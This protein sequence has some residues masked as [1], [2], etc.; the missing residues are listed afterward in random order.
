MAGKSE[1]P[2]LGRTEF[3]LWGGTAVVAVSA[4]AGL[5]VALAHVEQTVAEF[6]LACS[7]FRDDSELVRLNA[8]APQEVSVSSLLF[9]AVREAL[10]AARLT[11]GAVD[12]TVGQA[13]VA[14]RI[15]PQLG[16][17]ALQIRPAPGYEAVKLDEATLGITV[18]AGATLDLGATAKAL[19]ADM[20][21]EAAT[22]AAGCGVLVSLCGDVAVA[23]SSPEGGWRI[24][25]TDDH[26]D[27]VGAGQTVV[28]LSG[29]LATSS[30]TVRRTGSGADAIHHLISPASGRPVNGPWR[31]ASVTAGTCL[32]ANI[33][34]TAAIVLGNDAPKWLETHRMP[35][36]LV[37]HDGTVLR[38]LGW[39]QEG[40]DL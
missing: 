27:A 22:A 4:R 38:V 6:D 12:P 16:E 15:N 37:G 2:G 26:R 29:G 28:V 35:A 1:L 19:A 24:R 30:V 31:T 17:G 9:R 20:A 11:G 36:R 13:L 10:R 23:G 5:D 34:S 8:S 25:V 7:S 32:D 39:P 21:A 18:P 40:D 33:A 3:S 14:H